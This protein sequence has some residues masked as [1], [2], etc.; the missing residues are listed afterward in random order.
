MPTLG[1]Y[2]LAELKAA[3]DAA[4]TSKTQPNSITP[5][6]DGALRKLIAEDLF[7]KI[8]ASQGG[9]TAL[10]PKDLVMVTESRDLQSLDAGKILMLDNDAN[11]TMPAGSIL[12]NGELIIVGV[13]NSETS[14]IEK[15]PG[16]TLNIYSPNDGSGN[17]EL[18]LLEAINIDGQ[19]I[20]LP[21]STSVVDDNGV[22]KTALRYLMDKVD[23]SGGGGGA[24][25]DPTVPAYAK[26]L[27]SFSAIKANTDALYEPLFSKN[28]AFNKNFGTTSGTVVEGND[29]RVLN[30]QTAF[31]WGN[32]A[33]AGYQSLLVS[34]TNIKTINGNSVLGSGDLV[35]GGGSS[36]ET[37]TKAEIDALIAGNDLVKNA[38]YE[39]TGVHPTLYDDGT[40]SGTTVYL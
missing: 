9:S 33:L 19:T 40:T 13:V 35:I 11:L 24:E 21:I 1:Q 3:I 20:L 7:L 30:G 37:K 29:S 34:G 5:A 26:T 38:L 27:T 36:F 4:I 10:F 17:Q 23:D 28:T 31:G 22:N 39:I 8:Q 25:T 16:D 32:H 18:V 2:T 14:I 12:Q 15:A 6:V